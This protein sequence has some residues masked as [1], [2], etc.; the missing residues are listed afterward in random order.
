[1]TKMFSLNFRDVAKGLIVAVFSGVLIAAYDMV[2]KTS[3]VDWHQ[4]AVVAVGAGL[5]YLVKNFISDGNG[6]VAGVV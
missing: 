4:L 1:M 3:A 6:K 2:T 5:G